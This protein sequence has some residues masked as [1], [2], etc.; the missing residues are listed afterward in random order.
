MKAY[1]QSHWKLVLGINLL[2]GIALWFG[3]F[4][5]VSLRGT[6]PDILFPPVV[7]ILA[8]TTITI[9]PEEKKKLDKFIFIPSLLGGYLYIITGCVLLVPPF[10]LGF[11]FGASEIASEVLIEETPS[12]SNDLVAN[13]YFRPVGA[14][15]SGSGRIYVRISN[16]YMSFL[17]RDVYAGKT[18]SASA[19]SINYI[20]WLDEK[21]LYINE[22][23]ELISIGKI[24]F[25]MPAIAIVPI[26][27][28]GFIR[29]LISESQLTKPLRD[30]PI[31]PGKVEDD[32]T[33]H[34]KSSGQTIRIFLLPNTKKD[35]V[36]NWYLDIL[37]QSPWEIIDTNTSVS[38]GK[39][40]EYCIKVRRIVDNQEQIF[41]WEIED[42]NNA[43]GI[44]VTVYLSIPNNG[45]AC[46]P[47]TTK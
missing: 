36:Y 32:S 5:D 14:Y 29:D 4:T 16:K 6:I 13:V 17:E 27:V 18:Y 2:I 3:F 38:S 37:S 15:T 44:I 26:I 25:E 21:T 40:D 10:T 33:T 34:Y 39:L 30:I 8:T 42:G 11:L 7:A 45:E 46:K 47:L 24:E 23:N 20:K 31:Y 35:A 9:I 22:T 28:V 43:Q 1:L 41:Y 19:K 12:P